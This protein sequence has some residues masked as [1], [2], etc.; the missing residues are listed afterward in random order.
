MRQRSLGWKMKGFFILG[1][2]LMLQSLSDEVIDGN[3]IKVRNR[4]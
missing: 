1:V 3:N 4:V 2:L